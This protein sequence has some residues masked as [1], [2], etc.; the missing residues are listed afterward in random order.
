MTSVEAIR[1]SLKLPAAEQVHAKLSRCAALAAWPPRCNHEQRLLARLH[2][3]LQDPR[4]ENRRP[5][6]ADRAQ[7]SRVRELGQKAE[8][9]VG[10]YGVSLVERDESRAD[11]GIRIGVL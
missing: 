4:S 7:P 6:D 11:H 5:F 2:C 3:I 1:T 9:F 8:Q 10:R